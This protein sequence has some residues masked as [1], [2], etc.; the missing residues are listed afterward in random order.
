MNNIIIVHH[1]NNYCI[2]HRYTYDSCVIFPGHLGMCILCIT[3][4]GYVPISV[5]SLGVFLLESVLDSEL[6]H[7]N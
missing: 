5:V 3:L 1:N 4:N 6:G 2:V 7:D